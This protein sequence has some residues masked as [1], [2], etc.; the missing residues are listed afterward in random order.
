EGDVSIAG[1]VEAALREISLATPDL[2]LLD[3]VMPGRS[4]L[5]LLAELAE[6]GVRAPVIVLTATNTV[7]A[8][9]EAM[10]R[11]AAD[12]VTKPFEL[13]ALRIK[14]RDRLEKRD[15]LEEVER[16]RDEVE[17]RQ[18]FAG[19][20][21]RSDS[22]R[23]IFRTVERIAKAE[24][25][26]LVTGESG[27]GK[28]LVARAI[29]DHSPRA[30]GPFVAVNCGAIPRELIESELFGHEKGA[31]TG[32]TD[33]RTGR[34]ETADGGT[35]FLDEI[36]ELDAATQVKLLR[37]LQERTFERVGASRSISVDVRIVTA[38][39]R[40]LVEEVANGN[41][42]ED[43]YYRVAVVPVALPPLRERREDVRL[44][45]QSFVSRIGPSKQ[46]TPAALGSLEGYSWPG[47]VRELENA[48]E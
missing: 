28:E 10:K 32:A 4:G 23:T 7:N 24:A 17:D 13:E 48:I 19:M 21:G 33:R 12:F 44:L 45:A 43:L 8:A 3:L 46:L 35:L 5:D 22:M 40:D 1:D 47:N 36:G 9:V 30:D 11:G 27:T 29:H 18:Q 34:F 42:R 37:V 39:N 6:R 20:I 31:F 41:F 2:V 25:T 16:L 14:V 15:L 38:T 26:V